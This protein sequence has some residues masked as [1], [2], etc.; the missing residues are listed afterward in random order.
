MQSRIY[1]TLTFIGKTKRSCI[2]SHAVSVI[3]N[4]PCSGPYHPS[5]TPPCPSLSSF[6]PHSTHRPVLTCRG[7]FLSSL[8]AGTEFNDLFGLTT[9][10]VYGAGRYTTYINI[11]SVEVQMAEGAL[12]LHP[13]FSLTAA[14]H[15]TL[16]QPPPPPFFAIALSRPSCV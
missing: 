2:H 9:C 5:K 12:D 14:A 15:S 10:A 11:E 6:P 4:I 7:T 3:T 1:D 13:D 16:S 8:S